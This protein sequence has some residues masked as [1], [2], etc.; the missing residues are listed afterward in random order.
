[1][2]YLRLV[3]TKLNLP[4]R[5]F[6]FVKCFYIF[7]YLYIYIRSILIK[8]FKKNREKKN[9]KIEL[10]KRRRS[11]TENLFVFL[12]HALKKKNQIMFFPE[13]RMLSMFMPPSTLLTSV[14]T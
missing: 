10:K 3:N 4:T 1:M 2:R 8:M 13:F 5:L 12:N 11:R 6:Y 14:N 9:R 7:R